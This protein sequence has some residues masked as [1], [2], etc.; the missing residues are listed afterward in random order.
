MTATSITDPILTIKDLLKDNWNPANTSSVTPTFSTG[1]WDESNTSPQVTI[2]NPDD[3]ARG[4]T[5][6]T[7]IK[8]D[9]SGPTQEY[10]GEVDVGCW[11]V[12]DEDGH[13][14]N[15]KK[16]TYEFKE[17]IRRILMANAQGAGSL[18]RIALM[19]DTLVVDQEATPTLYH[20]VCEVGY[21]YIVE[22]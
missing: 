7:G 16:L 11:A 13:N 19:R 5:G 20:R 8:S 9:G 12:R 15:P 21:G 3:I 10:D 6:Y 14:V 18:N 4:T 17:E 2:T 1:W 22:P